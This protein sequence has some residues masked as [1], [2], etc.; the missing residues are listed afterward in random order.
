MMKNLH[1]TNIKIER[2]IITI[3]TKIESKLK[4]TKKSRGTW[5]INKIKNKNTDWNQYV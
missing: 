4:K 2:K 1:N 5:Y 3:L